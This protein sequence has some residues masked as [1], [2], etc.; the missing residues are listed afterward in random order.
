MGN[1]RNGYSPEPQGIDDYTGFK[2][3]LRS[4]RKDWQGFFTVNPDIR[5]QQDFVRGVP[6]KQALPY[7]RPETPDNF[8]TGIVR[9]EDL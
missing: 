1:S 4:L 5:N 3:P 6:D 8:L 7:S 2:V 9:P